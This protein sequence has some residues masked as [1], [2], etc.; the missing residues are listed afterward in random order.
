VAEGAGQLAYFDAGL[1]L[2]QRSM[3]EANLTA[4]LCALQLPKFKKLVGCMQIC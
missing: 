2:V 3:R 1:C 4:Q